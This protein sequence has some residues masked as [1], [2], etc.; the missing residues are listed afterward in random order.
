MKL[1]LYNFNNYANRILDVRNKLEDY[2]DYFIKSTPNGVNFNPNDGVNTSIILNIA[3]DEIPNYIICVPDGTLDIHSRW[4]VIDAN[5]TTGNQYRVN[6][7]RDVLADYYEEVYNS[8]AFIQ[9]GMIPM[10]SPFIYNSEGMSFNQI[11]KDE[12]PLYDISECPWIVAYLSTNKPT[13]E[14]KWLPYN[15]TADIEVDKLADWDYTVNNEYN[16]Y[17]DGTGAYHAWTFNSFTG[18]INGELIEY[19]WNNNGEQQTIS[20]SNYY[21]T[22]EQSIPSHNTSLSTQWSLVVDINTT[23]LRAINSLIS[24]TTSNTDNK[25]KSWYGTNITGNGLL[26]NV[27]KTIKDTSTGKVYKIG[28]SYGNIETVSNNIAT[29]SSPYNELQGIVDNVSEIIGTGNNASYTVTYKVQKVRP[30]FSELAQEEGIL[31]PFSN[32]GKSLRDAPYYMVAMPVGG[33]VKLKSG[34][35]FEIEY[36]VAYGLAQQMGRVLGSELYDIQLLPYCPLPTI[37]YRQDQK[38]IIDLRYLAENFDYVLITDEEG[39]KKSVMFYCTES[40]FNSTVYLT[41]EQQA[42]INNIVYNSYDFKVQNEC[43]K[44]RLCSPGYTNTYDFSMAKNGGFKGFNI[45]CTYKPFNPLIAVNPVYSGL[46]GRTYNRE[47]RGLILSGDFSMPRVTDTWV[48]YQLNNKNYEDIFNRQM[49]NMDVQQGIQRQ[50]AI[51]GMVAGSLQGGASGAMMGSVIGGGIGMGVGAALGTG[52]SLAAGIADYKNMQK[53][54]SEQKSYATDMYNYN[55][56]NIKATPNTLTKTSA[57]TILNKLVPFL[58]YYTCTDD[59]KQAFINKLSYNGMSIGIIGNVGTYID[60]TYN[61]HKYIQGSIIHIDIDNEEAHM[62]NAIN[63]EL[64]RGVRI[65]V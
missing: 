29:G 41:D 17:Q 44:W 11:K 57:F 45:Q 35:L 10:S 40:S 4:Y 56:G 64:M 8:T 39:T 55:L 59:E 1:C 31:I 12:I 9:K 43:D 18:S 47:Q 58:E 42:R 2:Q 14:V 6:L 61:N 50:E 36:D 65:I 20:N 28:V 13:N 3:D 19:S 33:N 5:R 46:Y 54:Q 38:P 37:L 7:L 30:V 49:V 34:D 62:R 24:K 23:K 21:G 25:I 26:D 63:D 27:G 60:N 52:A 51:A 53:L 22:Y 16:V 32:S 48:Q 15:V